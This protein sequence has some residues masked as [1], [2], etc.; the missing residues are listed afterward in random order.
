MN[1][2]LN[3]VQVKAVVKKGLEATQGSYRDLLGIFHLPLS[4][5]QKLM[6]FL[7]HHKLKP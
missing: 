7:R 4:D 5:Y 1:R 3:R 6:D 2:D